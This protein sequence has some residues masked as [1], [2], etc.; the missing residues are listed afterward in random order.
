MYVT[1]NVAS[2]QYYK[3]KAWRFE[4]PLQRRG[5]CLIQRTMTRVTV[6]PRSTT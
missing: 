4:L 3:T 6:S 2:L 5:V 1:V